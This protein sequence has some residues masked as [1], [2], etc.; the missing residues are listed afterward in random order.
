MAVAV[1]LLVAIG[2]AHFSDPSAHTA[3]TEPVR[4]WLG[5][6][7]AQL[8]SYLNMIFYLGRL[9]WRSGRCAGAGSCCAIRPV[10]RWKLRLFLLPV[11]VFIMAMGLT[12]LTGRLSAGDGGFA[13]L[14][15]GHLLVLA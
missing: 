6:S 9:Y 12:G 8:A 11:T 14:A 15:M 13:S 5:P 1:L 3:S 2:S 10:S 7:G 4:N